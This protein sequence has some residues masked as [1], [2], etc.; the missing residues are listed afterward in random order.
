MPANTMQRAAINVNKESAMSI[1]VSSSLTSAAHVQGTQYCGTASTGGASAKATDGSEPTRSGQGFISA[2][3]STLSSLGLNNATGAAASA[4]TG[5]NATSSDAA[6][7]LG[8]FL[9]SL[10]DAMH[11]Q[12]GGAVVGAGSA[13]AQGER[14]APPPDGGGM[15][16]DL[17]SLIASVSADADSTGD[18]S[19]TGTLKDSFASLLGSLGLDQSEATSKLGDFLKTLSSKLEANGPSG[20]LINTSA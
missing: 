1:S 2:I 18:S 9:H 19:A 5:A 10:M 7:A 14:P 11:S 4:D 17:R 12:R 16:A 13:P 8:D 15:E 6:Q 3:A 20:N